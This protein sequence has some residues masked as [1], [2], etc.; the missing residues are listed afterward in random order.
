MPSARTPFARASLL[1]LV[2]LSGSACA[3]GGSEVVPANQSAQSAVVL[4]SQD[5]CPIVLERNGTLE[6]HLDGNPSTGYAWEITNGATSVLSS[7]GAPSQEGES[8]V[9]G[10]P[11]EYVYRFDATA[12]GTAQLALAFR[13]PWDQATAPAQTF[14]CEITVR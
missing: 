9:P 4:R 12:P 13:Q 8:G 1:V 11:A 5:A 3:H 14:S 6:L 7:R 10:A 2:G